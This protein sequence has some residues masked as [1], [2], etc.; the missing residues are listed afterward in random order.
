MGSLCTKYDFFF[1]LQ[2]FPPLII[3][4]A[5]LKLFSYPITTIIIFKLSISKIQTNQNIKRREEKQDC[6]GKT[7]KSKFNY[8]R[9]DIL[10]YIPLATQNV[11]CWVSFSFIY[12]FIFPQ[13]LNTYRV[14]MKGYKIK[15]NASC[16]QL[17]K[18]FKE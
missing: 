12:L 7:S 15:K 10:N 17:L 1:L 2:L 8:S 14:H 13:S 9:G 6:K 4:W 5:S 11:F 18:L 3:L 16:L